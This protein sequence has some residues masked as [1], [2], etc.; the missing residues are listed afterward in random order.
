M[1]FR[2]CLHET[3]GV[4]PG[5]EVGLL[6]GVPLG[7]FDGGISS[8]T[9]RPLD[10]PDCRSFLPSSVSRGVGT[11]LKQSEVPQTAHTFPRS[12]CVLQDRSSSTAL[13]ISICACLSALSLPRTR[14]C[15]RIA[16]AKSRYDRL[17]GVAPARG[18]DYS[19]QGEV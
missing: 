8:A 15:C 16:P 13:G 17:A 3:A 18:P 1:L 12:T 6:L 5:E 9:P 11:S 2:I 10:S 14:L 4:E 7:L 19:H